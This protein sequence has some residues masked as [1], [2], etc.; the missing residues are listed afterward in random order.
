MDQQNK[1]K[2]EENLNK[3]AELTDKDLEKVA[4]GRLLT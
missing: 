3:S 2:H 4:G 1:A